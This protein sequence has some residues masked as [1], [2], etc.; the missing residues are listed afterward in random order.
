MCIRDRDDTVGKEG[1]EKA[2]ESFLRGTPGIRAVDR[3]TSG[4]ILSES[5]ITEPKPGDNIVLTIDIDLQDVYKR[6]D[7]T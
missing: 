7:V 1:V 2:F 6:Q 3:N 4:K 5:W